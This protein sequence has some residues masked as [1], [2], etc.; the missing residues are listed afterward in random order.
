MRAWL[1]VVMADGLGAVTACSSKHTEPEPAPQPA[2]AARGSAEHVP[3]T[4]TVPRAV[5]PRP[6]Q[7]HWSNVQTPDDCFFFSGPEGRDDQLVGEVRVETVELEGSAL[8][9]RIGTTLFEGTFVNG[10]IDVA[11]DHRYQFDGAWKTR[12]TLR[13]RLVDDELRATYRY[14]E[15]EL[16]TGDCPG[17]CTITGDVTIRR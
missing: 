6:H 7:I 4:G 10:A 5:P 8:R 3:P 9:L 16:A 12:E 14:E 17:R 15:C 11:R 1:L 2:P 13:G